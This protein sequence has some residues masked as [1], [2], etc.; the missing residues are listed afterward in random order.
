MDG[1]LIALAT[2]PSPTPTGTSDSAA[3]DPTAQLL[4]T[5]FGAALVTAL[6]GLAGAGLQG[7]REHK[8]WVRQERLAAYLDFL[9]FAHGMW[10]LIDDRERVRAKIDVLKPKVV[11]LREK[12]RNT[13][14]GAPRDALRAEMERY[15]GETDE[16][17][18]TLAE[19]D[20]RGKA[21]RASLIELSVA[22]FLLGPR[23]V[24]DAA[25]RVAEATTDS[26]AS[27]YSRIEEME[28]EMRWALK[29][30]L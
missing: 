19:M 18:A 23:R 5:I 26:A 17:L 29:I 1:L 6:A 20:E 16:L 11:E 22:C 10:D 15:D 2:T 14:P 27:V 3:L 9:R 4:L 13:P 12:Q 28:A 24:A 21:S 8:R 7:R 30:G 25:G